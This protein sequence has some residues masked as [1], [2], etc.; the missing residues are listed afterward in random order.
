MKPRQLQ[1]FLLEFTLSLVILSVALVVAMNLFTVSARQHT[2]TQTL[3]SLSEMM[4][5]DAE[6]LRH[7]ESDWDLRYPQTTTT[8]SYDAKGDVVELG[9]YQ[10]T[11]TR[12]I[13]DS[14]ETA[15]FVL[16]D[17]TRV[18]LTLRIVREVTP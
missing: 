8:V 11:V 12:S 18:W 1:F 16:K 7:P 5:Q 14:L 13:S 17:D 4:T 9:L 10:L 15:T 6:W 2:Q 3:R